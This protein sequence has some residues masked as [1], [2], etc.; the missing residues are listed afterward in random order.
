[1]MILLNKKTNKFM[2]EHY[3]IVWFMNIGAV[4]I[5]LAD[6][7]P[8]LSTISLVLAIGYTCHKWKNEYQKKNKK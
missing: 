7:N 4:T 6:I 5:T 2:H 3:L 1:M 8:V